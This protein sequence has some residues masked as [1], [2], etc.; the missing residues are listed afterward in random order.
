MH[1][2]WHDLF[3]FFVTST[4][5]MVTNRLELV[6]NFWS[7]FNTG[8]VRTLKITSFSVWMNSSTH[9]GLVDWPGRQCVMTMT[10]GHTCMWVYWA[11]ENSKT[12]YSTIT[13]G[14]PRISSRRGRQ[15]PPLGG[16]NIR[17][18]Q[19]FPKTARNRKNLDEF[20]PRARI[21]GHIQ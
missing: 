5:F 15:L 10:W 3:W 12:L 21:F 6:G 9:A 16:A 19:R 20:L 7:L 4:W 2:G 14:G 8:C 1:C 11:T 17:S 18:C 13:S